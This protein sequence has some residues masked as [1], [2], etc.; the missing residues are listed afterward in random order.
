MGWRVP[1]I[2]VG[3]GAE[4]ADTVLPLAKA[5]K[6]QLPATF[7][8]AMTIRTHFNVPAELGEKTVRV[9]VDGALPAKGCG[10]FERQEESKPLPDLIV[11]V[12]DE[13]LPMA[14]AVYRRDLA[15]RQHN[16]TLSTSPL[17][18]EGQSKEAEVVIDLTLDRIGRSVEA[19]VI[20]GL[21]VG[22]TEAASLSRGDVKSK[23]RGLGRSVGFELDGR[24]EIA[25][26]AFAFEGKA[27]VAICR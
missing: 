25:G 12:G 6:V 8:E 21:R 5:P 22:K 3:L 10:S 26:Y 17:G 16:L 23:L 13:A 19:A 9:E 2:E 14:G 18:C 15:T 7:E 4:V 20:G 1:R 27:Q 24:A 11:T